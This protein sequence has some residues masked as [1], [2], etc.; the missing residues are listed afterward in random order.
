MEKKP[1]SKPDRG[2]VRFAARVVNQR[3]EVVQEGEWT[4]LMKAIKED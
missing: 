2:I 4:L 1:T 3:D